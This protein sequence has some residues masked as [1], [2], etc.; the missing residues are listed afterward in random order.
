MSRFEAVFPIMHTSILWEFH[1]MFNVTSA[2]HDK[3]DQLCAQLDKIRSD[4]YFIPPNGH[5]FGRDQDEDDK[6]DAIQMAWETTMADL[7]DLQD[8]VNRQNGI[9]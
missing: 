8:A 9:E 1:I 7:D 4:P 3:H 6:Y 2:Q 5:W